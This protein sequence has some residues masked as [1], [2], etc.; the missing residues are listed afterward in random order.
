MYTNLPYKSI[1]LRV[2][3]I[4]DEQLLIVG[5]LHPLCFFKVLSLKTVTHFSNIN[6]KM[7]TSVAWIISIIS[8][9]TGMSLNLKQLHQKTES[10]IIKHDT[11]ALCF[12]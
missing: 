5:I 9:T 1:H 6:V 4:T 11:S 2:F 7:A 8:I 10:A 12:K 3:N